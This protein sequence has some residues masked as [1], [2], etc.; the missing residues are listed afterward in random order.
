[1]CGG[2]SP[3]RVDPYFIVKYW[4]L[5]S[6]CGRTVAAAF[7]L[8][9]HCVQK[10]VS[11]PRGRYVCDTRVLDQP[12]LIYMLHRYSNAIQVHL[13]NARSEHL[14]L[15]ERSDCVRMQ[16]HA[17]Q[18]KNQITCALHW[19]RT[20]WPRAS[21]ETIVRLVLCW[22][23]S[24]FHHSR[25]VHRH[26]QL[27][28]RARIH[29]PQERCCADLAHR[30]RNSGQLWSNGVTAGNVCVCAA[31][32]ALLNYDVHC[33]IHFHVVHLSPRVAPPFVSLASFC[34]YAHI[35]ARASA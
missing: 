35:C 16:C 13:L 5:C 18:P 25:R 2:A 22:V 8:F 31:A 19:P 1:M 24:E 3:K 27:L 6:L 21:S 29:I 4:I 7:Y 34:E 10:R 28:C 9:V 33:C 11:G 26:F 14:Y 20:D 12:H 30:L 32:A 15:N 17:M 23:Q